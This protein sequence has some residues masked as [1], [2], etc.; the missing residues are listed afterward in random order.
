M[1][2]QQ[3]SR[4][5]V[6]L[7]SKRRQIRLLHLLPPLPQKTSILSRCWEYVRGPSKTL[8]TDVIRCVFSVVALDDQPQFE[9]L[10]Y[11]WGNPTSD[12]VVELEG[13]AV[14]VTSNLHSALK[15]LRRSGE[16]RIIWA[17]ALCIDQENNEERS[18]QVSLMQHIYTQASAVVIYL[19]G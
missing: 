12:A 7:D 15:H 13:R 9:A 1:K 19:F 8:D 16:E 4:T 18:H 2:S 5:Y 3:H 17:D 14:R 11:V 6:P 10:S